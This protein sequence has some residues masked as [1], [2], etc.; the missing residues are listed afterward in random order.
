MGRPPT[1]EYH[2]NMNDA[3]ITGTLTCLKPDYIKKNI[4]TDFPLVLNIEPTNYCDLDCYI[5]PRKI[6]I[7]KGYKK[8]GHMD[9]K[10]YKKIID[11]CSKYRKLVMLNLHKDGESLLHPRIYDMIRYAK[12][13]DVAEKIHMNTNAVVLNKKNAYNY[14][15]SGIDDITFSIDAARAE[16]FN[17]IKRKNV[18]EKVEN[19]VKNFIEYRDDIGLDKPFV[20]VKIME[21][22]DISK[23]E[24]D[25]FFNKW[26]GIADDVQVTGV[27]SWSGSVNVEATDETYDIDCPCPLI[28]YGIAINWDGRVSICSLDWDCSLIVGDIT[29]NS[30]HDVWNGEQI[31]KFREL[32]LYHRDK[33][34]KTCKD[35]VLWSCMG[36]MKDFLSKKTE[37]LPEII[38]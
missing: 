30:I 35:C 2:K 36:D 22:E 21:F 11:E 23:D 19:N 28:W 14:I 31:K 37:F 4:N 20:R 1:K 26:K 38:V 3:Y 34:S 12:I 25:E 13:M 7:D 27:H 15:F 6:A 5:C 32:E 10:L 33:R 29:K 9:F 24:I 16:T 8:L 17:K 18:L